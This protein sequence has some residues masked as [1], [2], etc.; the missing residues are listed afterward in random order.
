[1]NTRSCDRQSN[2][3]DRLLTKL[4]NGEGIG[5]L[6]MHFGKEKIPHTLFRPTLELKR[7]FS[8]YYVLQNDLNWCRRELELLES[9]PVAVIISNPSAVDT[10]HEVTLTSARLRFRFN[11]IAQRGS[12]TIYSNTTAV[13]WLDNWKEIFLIIARQT[14]L[15]ALAL[16]NM[17]MHGNTDDADFNDIS[18]TDSDRGLALV[19]TNL[20][21][22]S[23][24]DVPTAT[25]PTGR[26]PVSASFHGTTAAPARYQLQPG[27]MR[28]H[29]A[30]SDDEVFLINPD[31]QQSSTPLQQE[32][33]AAWTGP[34]PPTLAAHGQNLGAIPKTATAWPTAAAA[35]TS[36]PLQQ[37]VQLLASALKQND[38]ARQDTT[39]QRRSNEPR[40]PTVQDLDEFPADDWYTQLP[41][42]WNI[43]PRTK[44]SEKDLGKTLKE[45]QGFT[46]FD[47]SR[48]KY[49]T[50]RNFVIT[51]IHRTTAGI[52]MKTMALYQ[53]MDLSKPEIQDLL[54]AMMWGADFYRSIIT[55]LEDT[56]GGDTNIELF[57]LSEINKVRSVEYRNVSDYGRWITKVVRYREVMMQHGRLAEVDN[58]SL[59][60]S[61]LADFWPKNVKNV[62]NGPP[63]RTLV[64]FLPK[65]PRFWPTV[66]AKEH[67]KVKNGPPWRTFG[68][69]M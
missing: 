32:P 10:V 43:P 65:M 4:R 13:H 2:D 54:P 5:P 42:P 66:W 41:A 61:A 29:S 49:V 52:S 51:C 36:D 44:T 8:E 15:R 22:R 45:V 18:M 50:W 23:A 48:D 33:P 24:S 63:W 27:S 53:A 9:R 35:A 14:F 38:T 55:S 56:Y 19:D 60:W 59:K 26:P 31:A 37:L 6:N 46:K 68:P 30:R 7:V 16:R 62:K 21:S 25:Q 34:P 17:I 11:D 64:K 39:Q 69:K 67:Q 57:Y 40:P 3:C 28:Q 58:M 12:E 1:M 47:G 20:R